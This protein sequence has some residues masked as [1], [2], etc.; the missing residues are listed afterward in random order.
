MLRRHFLAMGATAGLALAQKKPDDSIIATATQD[1]TPRVG[2]VLS[3]FKE[4]EDHDGTKLPGLSDPRPPGADLTSAQ[5]DAMVRRAIDLAATRA[6]EFYETVEAEDWVVIK[7][8]IPTCYGLTPET[9]DGGAHQPYIPGSVTDPRVVRSVISYLAEHKRG[10][11]F[12]VVEGSPQWLTAD[13]SK[14]AVDGWTT[15]WGGAFD[16]LSYRKM[17]A[18]LSARFPGVRFEIADLNF[19]DSLDYPTA[20]KALAR[21]NPAGTYT[22]P[23]II[24]QCDRLISVAPLATDPASG[25]SL[26]MGNYLGIAPGS[27]YGFPK[28]GLLKLGSAD[29]I[30]IDL[31][32]YHPADLA[33][34]GGC[35]GLEGEGASVHHNLVV[36]G[37][38][39]VCVDTV[40]ATIMG[41]KPA[42]LPFLKLGEKKGFGAADIDV[43]WMRGNDAEDARREF[44]K[45]GGWHAP[46]KASGA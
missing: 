10:L 37:M 44:K 14:S 20:G 42:E 9:K 5:L 28:D 24:R 18:D 16:G 4:G 25:V 12:T 11:R 29:E 45:P 26:S 33:V 1:T 19:A 2:I 39:A 46:S 31:F 36:A 21:N 41:F 23:K 34:V 15:D 8:H 40:A 17:V 3:S 22:I 13:R 27:K 6:E 32:G 35:W 43:I 30:M 7:T 38:K